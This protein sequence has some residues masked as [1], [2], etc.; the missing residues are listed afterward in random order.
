MLRKYLFMNRICYTN[1]KNTKWSD[2][3]DLTQ[4]V[5]VEDRKQIYEFRQGEDRCRSLIG[6]MLLLY[7]LKLNGILTIDF[8]PPLSYN[9]YLKPYLEN[10]TGSFNISHSGDFV[11][12]VLSNNTNIGVDIEKIQDIDLDDY[13]D[14]LTGPEYDILKQANRVDFFR[15]WSIKEAVM[16]AD[17]RGFYLDPLNITLPKSGWNNNFS[18][19]VEE[20]EWNISSQL[21]DTDYMLA[22]AAGN[23]DKTIAIDE[24]SLQILTDPK[25]FKSLG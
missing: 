3:K 1:I 19:M 8:L 10:Y 15:L 11:V 24:V 5:S 18:L 6:K 4:I 23:N 20:N 9:E 25:N 16:K 2:I 14:V 7:L 21:I 13:K 22:I 12:C 17:G